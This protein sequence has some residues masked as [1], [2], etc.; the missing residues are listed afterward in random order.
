LCLCLNHQVDHLGP[1][2]RLVG[3]VVQIAR[4]LAVH[5]FVAGLFEISFDYLSGLC[6]RVVTCFTH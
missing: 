4:Y 2:G 6:P 1:D 3:T 5:I